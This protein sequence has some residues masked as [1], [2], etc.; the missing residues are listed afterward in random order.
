MTN[1]K[2]L[3]IIIVILVLIVIGGGI[4]LLCNKGAEEEGEPTTASPSTEAQTPATD[5]EMVDCGKAEDPFCFVNR[6]NQCLPVTAKMMGSDGVT[7]IEITILGVEN[8][9]CHFQRKINDVANLDCYF[10]KGTLNMDTLDQTFGN[11]KGLQKVV[12][13]AC[14]PAGW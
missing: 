1:S 5:K 8:E 2:V 12:D 11:D 9:K 6:M 4:F 7:S 10:P 3:Y 13:D 14:S